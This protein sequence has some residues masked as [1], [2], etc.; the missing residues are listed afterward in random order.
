MGCS[1][2]L[3]NTD[4]RHASLQI[5]DFLVQLSSDGLHYPRSYLLQ[6]E[7]S[8]ANTN[9][10]ACVRHEPFVASSRLS[11]VGLVWVQGPTS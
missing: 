7:S 11:I 6:H 8:L 4:T 5:K 2:F 9:P 3:L 1:F 10:A